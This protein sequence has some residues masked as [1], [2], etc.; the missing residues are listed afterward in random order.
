MNRLWVKLT[1]AF[2]AVSLVAIGVVAAF[3]LR[4]TGDQFREYVVATGMGAQGGWA[5]TLTDYYAGR[6]SWEGVEILLA[7]L[8]PGG[9]GRGRGGAMMAGPDLAIADSDGRVIA[10]KSGELVGEQLPADVLAQGVSLQ[11]SS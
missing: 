10:S 3:A 9:M 6:G 1:A 2:L 4:T 7:E 5:D 11:L 8:G